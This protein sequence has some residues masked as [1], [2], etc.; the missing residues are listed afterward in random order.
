[1]PWVP[2]G[3]IPR[4]SDIRNRITDQ[5][6]KK[7]ATERKFLESE[8]KMAML[9]EDEAPIIRELEGLNVQLNDLQGRARSLQA[10]IR[11]LDGK[12]ASSKEKRGGLLREIRAL[13]TYT[14]KRLVAFYKMSRL[15]I[16]PILFSGT[17]L[18]VTQQRMI[19]LERI[20]DHDAQTRETLQDKKAR[21]DVLLGK[22]NTQKEKHKNL[23]IQCDKET[24]IMAEKRA[25]RAQLLKKIQTEKGLTLAA[26]L[27]FE[28]SVKEL[29]G[30]VRSLR[31]QMATLKITTTDGPFFAQKGVLPMP[32][33]GDL[34]GFFGAYENDGPYN[35]K[36]FRNGVNIK[37]RPGN[38][39]QAVWNGQVIYSDWF[40]GY[41]NIVII[42]HGAHYYSLS[43]Q[44][45][46]VFA[47]KG[48]RVLSGDTVGTVGDTAT[49]GGPGLYF[50]IRH[51]GKPLDPVPWFR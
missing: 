23:L 7:R 15:G 44:L 46:Q 10:N 16:A 49:H 28:R 40:K 51:R 35:V 9:A 37:A 30:T 45:D 26:M 18:F 17:S 8:E 27:S 24:S 43:A 33:Q 12:M 1:L 39:V 34:A 20:L 48:D 13:E 6:A 50:E 14:A 29:D 47:K 4:P 11:Q 3:Q 19:A 31:K 2:P 41:G 25:Q 38:P 32:A 36:G 42:D 5:E 21:L 22:M